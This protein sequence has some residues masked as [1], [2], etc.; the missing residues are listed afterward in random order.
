MTD[1]GRGCRTVRAVI[2][3]WRWRRNPLRRA[4]DRC[5]AWTALVSLLLMAVAA[6]A[7][8]WVCGTLT[9][10]ALQR[11]VREQR[12]RLHATTAVVVRLAPGASRLVTDPEAAGERGPRA[13]VVARW[14]APDGTV[15]S[16]TVTTW[17]R[18]VR[19]GSRV[20]IWTGPDGRAAQRPMDAP[21]ARTH[22]VLAGVGVALLAAG[23]VEG[24]RRLAVRSMTR[25][26]YAR[27]DRAWA[28]TGPD[29]GRTGTGN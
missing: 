27:I 19:S 8:G 16:G 22:A 12:A 21:A 3:V 23:L 10:T 9:D 2:G 29:W 17:S 26:R 24:G 20:E 7:L 28:E 1:A 5:E 25:R 14:R 18:S 13:S 15:R 6:P 4:T 11:T